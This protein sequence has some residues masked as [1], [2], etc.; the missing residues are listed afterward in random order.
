[1]T[2]DNPQGLTP[3]GVWTRE[4]V[5]TE[6]W[7][8]V[9]GEPLPLDKNPEPGSVEPIRCVLAEYLSPACASVLDVG[10]GWVWYHVPDHVTYTGVDISPPMLELARALHPRHEFIEASSFD[11]PFATGQYEGVRSSGM[12]RHIEAWEP[13]LDEMMRVANKRMAFTHLVSDAPGKDG[14][15]QWSV[16]TEA[17]LDRL[18]ASADVTVETHKEKEGHEYECARFM[19]EL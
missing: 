3:P 8:N 2:T 10:C 13:A 4:Y 7:A 18:P 6:L 9:Y 12:L 16:R 11:L 15:Y 5:R 19:V 1:M 17:V 14:P